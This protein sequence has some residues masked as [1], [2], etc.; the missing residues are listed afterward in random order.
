[1][2]RFGFTLIKNELFENANDILLGSTAKNRGY[3]NSEGISKLLE[4]HR[5]GKSDPTVRTKQIWNLL[6]LEM[7][8]QQNTFN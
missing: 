1:M 8:F 3:L 7:W 5:S 6:C 2:L 4:Y